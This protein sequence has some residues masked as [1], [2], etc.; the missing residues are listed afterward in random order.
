[1]VNSLAADNKGG[2]RLLFLEEPL[3]QVQKPGPAVSSTKATWDAINVNIKKFKTNLPLYCEVGEANGLNEMELLLMKDSC[4]GHSVFFLENSLY[5]SGRDTWYMYDVC[6][7]AKS[8][9]SC[10]TL[11]NPMNCSLPGS[12]VHGSLQARTL[13]WVAMPSSRGSSQLRIK[14]VSLMSPA[15]AGGFFT[16]SATWE[17]QMYDESDYWTS[18]AVIVLDTKMHGSPSLEEQSHGLQYLFY[19]HYTC[20][21]QSVVWTLSAAK[22]GLS[23]IRWI[24]LKALPSKTTW[25]SI[26]SPRLGTNWPS[27]F[28]DL[29]NI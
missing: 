3:W 21:L 6:M 17:A 16:T 4:Y 7:H 10:L 13:E 24:N 18:K 8:L 1:M 5:T 25:L 15:L 23:F 9:Q 27:W 26:I 22:T 12:S 28:A 11:W 2:V 29:I 19:L 14:P 20:L